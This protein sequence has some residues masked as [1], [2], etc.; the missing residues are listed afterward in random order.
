MIMVQS[1]LPNDQLMLWIKESIDLSL[2]ECRKP[3]S[4]SLSDNRKGAFV[5]K[6]SP[7]GKTTWI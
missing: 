1:V 2:K 5:E 3:A 7:L 6:E 4:L